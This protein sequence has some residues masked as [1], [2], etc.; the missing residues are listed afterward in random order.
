MD[1]SKDRL[2]KK[3]IGRN[4]W[5]KGGKHGAKDDDVAQEA[6]NPQP[7]G[8]KKTQK[9]NLR[10]QELKTRAALLVEHTP[11]GEQASTIREQL[12]SMEGVMGYKLCVV[13]RAGRRLLTYFP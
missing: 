13:E 12:Q 4:K 8:A 2:K 11:M 7:N 5:Y 1:S 3:W 9:T 6:A 10:S